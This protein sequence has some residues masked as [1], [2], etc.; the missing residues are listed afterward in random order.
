MKKELYVNCDDTV[1][2]YTCTYDINKIIKIKK[3]LDKKNKRKD[4]TLNVPKNYFFDPM[5]YFEEKR[6]DHYSGLFKNDFKR[7]Q[8]IVHRIEKCSDGGIL[9]KYSVNR[10]NKLS[11]LCGELINDN[12][13]K[14][15][16]NI[17]NG[18]II[19]KLCEYEPESEKEK[20]GLIEILKSFSF[21]EKFIDKNQYTEYTIEQKCEKSF[22][23]LLIQKLYKIQNINENK[24]SLPNQ[25]I[26]DIDKL[27]PLCGEYSLNDYIKKINDNLIFE[28]IISPNKSMIKK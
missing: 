28:N 16:C 17:Q 11:N 9:L 10:N 2:V 1:K 26:N 22:F 12:S 3:Y 23:K 14:T 6:L 19:K 5:L 8:T 24:V 18:Y 4:Y 13:K 15:N 7:F 27:Y 20:K 25:Y 21:K